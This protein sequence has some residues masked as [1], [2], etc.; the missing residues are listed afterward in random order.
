MIVWLWIKRKH[1]PAPGVPRDVAIVAY[2][3]IV[4][5]WLSMILGVLTL[6]RAAG[7]F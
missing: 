2:T 1:T 7:L 6:C 5:G 3:L 4:F